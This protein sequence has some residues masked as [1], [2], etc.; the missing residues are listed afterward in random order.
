M[1]FINHG[2]FSKIFENNSQFRA[3]LHK[4]RRIKPQPRII[5]HDIDIEE[6]KKLYVN[7]RKR[8]CALSGCCFLA[9]IFCSRIQPIIRCEFNISSYNS[10]VSTLIFDTKT[11]KHC[12]FISKE[13][14]KIVNEYMIVSEDVNY[15]KVLGFTKKCFNG[16]GT[17]I[18]RK[19]GA[20]LLKYVG[21]FQDTEIRLYGNWKTKDTLSQS[22]TRTMILD[23]IAK[24][25]DTEI[26]K[27][28][29]GPEI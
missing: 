12:I 9:T 11:T 21:L 29:L 2:K 27:M 25:W 16:S 24:F 15:R 4:S 7:F 28:G 26:G 23:K 18:C 17:H 13:I 1:V 3:I 5:K 14:R 10:K 8:K 19:S 20:G 22:Y 6:L